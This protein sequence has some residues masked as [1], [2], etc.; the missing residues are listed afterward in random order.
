MSEQKSI[1][2]Q[3][4]AGKGELPLEWT[5]KDML[6]SSDEGKEIVHVLDDILKVVKSPN[7]PLQSL[8][9]QF[10]KVSASSPALM[11]VLVRISL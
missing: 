3:K 8:S 1:V 2:S 6:A 10:S 11:K 7:E 5:V 9:K 4:E